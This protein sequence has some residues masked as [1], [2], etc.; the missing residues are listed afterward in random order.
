MNYPEIVSKLTLEE[1]IKMVTGFGSWHTFPVERLGIGSVMMTDGPIGLRKVDEGESQSHVSVCFPSGCLTACSFDR[2]LLEKMGEALGKECQAYEVGIILGPAVNIKRSPLCGRN[3]EYYSEDPYLTGEIAAAYIN[4][5]QSQGV[6][7]SLKHFTMNNQEYRR[8]SYDAIVDERALREIYL[9][10]YEIAVKKS[11]PYTLM[12]SYNKV[13]GEHTSESRRIL[14]DILRDEWGFKGAVMSDWGAVHYRDRGIAAGLD[15]EMP[16]NNWA[17]REYISNAIADGTLTIEQLDICVDRIVTLVK[18]VKKHAENFEF[19]KDHDLTR[20]IAEESIVLLKNRDGILPLKPDTRV[21]VL[22]EFAV[23]PRIQGG[24]SAFINCYAVDVT[25][26]EMK[27]AGTVTYSKAFP[28]DSDRWERSELDAALECAKS[29]DVAVV[30]AGLPDSYESEGFD[31][32]HIHLPEGQ[33]MLIRE[34]TDAG[35]PTV[36][37]L[38]NGAVVDMPWIGDVDG[39]VEAYL[40]G[41]GSGTAV[42]NILYGKVNPSGKLAET[43]PVKLEDNPS[44]LNFPGDGYR[45]PYAESIY[46]GY[47]YYQKK[48]MNVLFPFGFGLSYTSFAYSGLR[49]DRREMKDTDTLAVSVD[50]TNTGDVFGK[51]AVQLY[52]SDRGDQSGRPQRPV[53]ELKGFEKVALD[54][55]ETKTVTFT[56]DKRAFAYYEERVSDWIVP[57]SDYS[58]EIGASAE[59]IRLEETV[60][61]EA[62]RSAPLEIRQ[63]T[64]FGEL[65]R[66]PRTQQYTLDNLISKQSSGISSF[67]PEAIAALMDHNPIRGLRNFGNEKPE[68]VAEIIYELKELVREKE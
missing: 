58:I 10:G 36:V 51:E 46:V 53:R 25:L 56:L 38:Q 48:K 28:A 49:L 22:G 13:N 47:R 21:A 52:V 12:C 68:R 11:Q 54:P 40:A 65:L 55:G 6:G 31:R 5:V 50:I 19:E 33:N 67:T 60:R 44:F 34:L 1:K 17:N 39:L 64:V 26:E 23:K 4:G 35:I 61:V 7:T 16:G 15:L 63:D 2:D 42:T 20:R 24:G 18:R 59:D 3:F 45:V 14:T 8:M 9:T 30:M 43:F 37:V 57:T 32:T 41:E 29:A 66:D 62:T 27:K